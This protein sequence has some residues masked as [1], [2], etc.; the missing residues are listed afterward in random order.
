MR[1]LSELAVL[2]QDSKDVA[3]RVQVGNIIFR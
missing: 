3:Y 1:V 2:L